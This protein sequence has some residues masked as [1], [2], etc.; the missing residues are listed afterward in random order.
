[1]VEMATT[2]SISRIQPRS[3]IYLLGGTQPSGPYT[4]VRSGHACRRSS[5]Q[6]RRTARIVE[7]D[8]LLLFDGAANAVTASTALDGGAGDD[9]IERREPLLWRRRHG[10][11]RPQRRLMPRTMRS[12]IQRHAL[13]SRAPKQS[14]CN[15]IWALTAFPISTPPKA[16][17]LRFRVAEFGLKTDALGDTIYQFVNSDATLEGPAATKALAIH[18]RNDTHVL[19]FDADGTGIELCPDR[20]RSHVHG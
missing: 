13:R 11:D 18:L 10:P 2:G 16:T 5:H 14:I 20:H 9:W 17:S 7:A 12:S 15:T 1:M 8:D 6:C 4:A 3:S 19:W